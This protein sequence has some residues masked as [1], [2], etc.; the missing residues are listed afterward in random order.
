ALDWRA[1]PDDLSDRRARLTSGAR[2]DFA[3]KH[4]DDGGFWITTPTFNGDPASEAHAELTALVADMKAKQDA[5][6]AAP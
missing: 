4:F 3:L 2:P 5:L 1:T 6:R